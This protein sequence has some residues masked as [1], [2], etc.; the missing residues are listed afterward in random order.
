M[1]E[2]IRDMTI[3]GEAHE[4]RKQV[5][6]DA[7]ILRDGTVLEDNEELFSI[8]GYSRTFSIEHKAPAIAVKYIEKKEAL[9][10]DMSSL[11]F[12]RE[13]DE[14]WHETGIYFETLDMIP[15]ATKLAVPLYSEFFKA[16]DENWTGAGY[17][18]GTTWHFGLTLVFVNGKGKAVDGIPQDE[19]VV[20]RIRKDGNFN[21][22]YP[23]EG[24]LLKS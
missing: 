23:R 3:M 24:V 22:F 1:A 18:D 10:L 9:G 11:F 17:Q 15:P 21:Y 8:G 4:Y 19:I 20:R 13:S 7:Y 12:Y 16:A 14:R 6:A 5:S 2:D